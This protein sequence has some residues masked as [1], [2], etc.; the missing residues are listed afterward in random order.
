M[1]RPNKADDSY[2][3]SDGGRSFTPA[4]RRLAGFLSFPFYVRHGLQMKERSN[5]VAVKLAWLALA[6]AFGT[7]SRYGL[8]GLMQ[9]VCGESFPWGNIH[10]QRIGLVPLRSGVDLGRGTAHH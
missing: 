1:N 10:G 6:G 7:L 4:P 8:A 3:A 9:R 2:Y 5:R